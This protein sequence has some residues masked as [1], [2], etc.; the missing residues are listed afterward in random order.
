MMQKLNYN[1][2]SP[3][4]KLLVTIPFLILFFPYIVTSLFTLSIFFFVF[5]VVITRLHRV[6]YTNRF[7]ATF[8]IMLCILLMM[9][10]TYGDP[11][12]VH[13]ELSE[14][15]YIFSHNIVLNFTV[16]F[17]VY[18][19]GYMYMQVVRA[20]L[21][22]AANTYLVAF[23]VISL[24]FIIAY[25]FFLGNSL[26]QG[27]IA[28]ALLPYFVLVI[29]RKSGYLLLFFILFGYLFVLLNRTAFFG[30]IVFIITYGIYPFLIKNKG[31]YRIYII[32]FFVTI[33]LLIF[34]YVTGSFEFLNEFSEEYFSKRIDSGR[35]EIWMA[36]F[37]YISLKPWYGY[38]INQ[39]STLLE[40][41]SVSNRTI[42]SHN[43][44]IEILLRGGFLFLGI[45]LLLLYSIWMS[46]YSPIV[47]K[48]KRVMASGFV[49]MLFVAAGLEVVLTSNIILNSLI[50]FS[51]G[52]GGHPPFVNSN[53]NIIDTR[54]KK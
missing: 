33:F 45:F 47:N 32:L 34:S 35:S 19:L 21:F 43:M 23:P 10:W 44:Y 52:S 42:S 38:G 16:F 5:M 18:I 20:P 9:L 22:I 7:L 46:F 24:Y 54:E 41:S 26:F 11:P 3:F 29:N 27:V 28:V 6:V 4:I 30:V 12:I 15:N 36:L 1:I 2:N 51:W 49:S 25:G 39:Y 13:I 17:F 8:F 40:H 37:D 31:L 14:I 53:L 50:W 48:V